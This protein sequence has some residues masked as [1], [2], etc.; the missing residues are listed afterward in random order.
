[1]KR[2][3][4]FL[5]ISLLLLFPAAGEAAFSGQNGKIFFVSKGAS[6]Q[7]YSVRPDG[8][9]RTQVTKGALLP[10]SPDVSPSGR[11]L[12]FVST[13][14]GNR[15]FVCSALGGRARFVV[16]GVSPA[17]S[18]GGG[19]LAYMTAD[20]LGGNNLQVINL[21]TKKSRLVFSGQGE[22][23]ANP[24]WDASGQ[25]IIFASSSG[26]SDTEIYS[27]P[28]SGGP[29]SVQSPG[30]GTPYADF[31]RPDV[32][33]DGSSILAEWSSIA[34]GSTAVAVVSLDSG[35]GDVI[36]SPPEFSAQRYLAPV[37]SPDG[38]FFLYSTFDYGSKFYTLSY[39]PLALDSDG[40]EI[41]LPS[42]T[43]YPEAVW[44]P[45]VS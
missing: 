5:P 17:F 18:P 43:V 45:A 32:S 34:S 12:A 3:I 35:I 15:I 2:L 13:S 44:A 14:K 39:L 38:S 4:L 37:F 26:G 16:S 20:G 36:W 23:L 33:P 25:E 29:A 28:A 8:S 24:V 19:S 42:S 11:T 22:P 21:R 27:V 41:N 40:G 7:I 10:R 31:S 1:M 6:Q 30:L 9:K